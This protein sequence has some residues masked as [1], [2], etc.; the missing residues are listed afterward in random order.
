MNL[1]PVLL[2]KLELALTRRPVQAT[3]RDAVL[4]KIPGRHTP[5]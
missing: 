2:E 1:H 3:R 4:P 5:W